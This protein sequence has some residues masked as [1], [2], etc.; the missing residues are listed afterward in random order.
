MYHVFLIHS[1]VEGH[2]G[3]FQALAIT[4][5]DAMNIVEHMSKYNVYSLIGA[6]R[7]SKE[8]PAYR[9]QPRETRQQRGP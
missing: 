3:W 8:K 4:N 7:H 9:P 5:N 2:L 1:L 6:F